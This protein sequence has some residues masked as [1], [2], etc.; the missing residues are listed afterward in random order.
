MASLVG[1]VGG[2]SESYERSKLTSEL[3]DTL[4][5][6]IIKP[7]DKTDSSSSQEP[8]LGRREKIDRFIA[9]IL[10]EGHAISRRDIWRVAGYK[11]RTEF[12]RYQR[13]AKPQ[14]VKAVRTFEAILSL[15][16]KDFLLRLEKLAP[17]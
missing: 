9:A 17:R 1:L 12:E 13:D 14:N 10:A 16:P 4:S 8:A 11:N 6:W 7:K 5:G 3:T 15:S 2:V